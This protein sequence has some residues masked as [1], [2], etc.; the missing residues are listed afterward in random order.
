MKQPEKEETIY[1]CFIGKS[2]DGEYIFLEDAFRYPDGFKWLTWTIFK[3]LTEY[4]LDRRIREYDWLELWQ[5]AVF[6]WN[7]TQGYDD[8]VEE[9]K[10]IWEAR[11]IVRDN[12]YENA[13]WT[14][15]AMSVARQNEQKEYEYSDCIGGWRIFEHKMLSEDYYEYFIPENLRLLRNL[16]YK[17]EE[18]DV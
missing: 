16:Y 8:W 9:I 2:K 5:E 7:C 11:Q 3:F 10:D 1:N 13:E 6:H 12:S 15:G 4:E 18:K 14:Q 17:Y